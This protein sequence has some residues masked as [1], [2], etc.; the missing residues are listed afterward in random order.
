[1]EK[2]SKNYPEFLNISNWT[3]AIA[4]SLSVLTKLAVKKTLDQKFYS[5]SVFLCANK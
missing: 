1:M 5:L 3:L 4:I 2:L